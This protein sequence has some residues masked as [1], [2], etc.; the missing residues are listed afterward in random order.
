MRPGQLGPP[1]A[2][3]PTNAWLP[4]AAAQAQSP[5]CCRHVPHGFYEKQLKGERRAGPA[6]RQRCTW[7]GRAGRGGAGTRVRTQGAAASLPLP[8]GSALDVPTACPPA[9]CAE[10]FTQF[11]R[12]T[13]VRLSRSKKT[14]NSRGYAFL[15]FQSAEVRRPRFCLLQ[16]AFCLLQLGGPGRERG[17][18]GWRGSWVEQ[19]SAGAM[20]G[21]WWQR[22]T[23]GSAYEAAGWRQGQA[24]QLVPNRSSA[25]RLAHP[26]AWACASRWP[27]RQPLVFSTRQSFAGWLAGWLTCA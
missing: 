13:K 16:L 2:G 6:G 20:P 8:A 18:R 12:V 23:G 27:P 3:V 22:A 9:A 5:V 7:L 19:G 21:G 11:G 15:E 1:H 10:Y 26:P 24:E 17:G 25:C 14:A 4:L